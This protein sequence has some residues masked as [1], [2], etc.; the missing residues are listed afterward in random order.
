MIQNLFEAKLS[1]GAGIGSP[2]VYDASGFSRPC[3]SFIISRGRN[4]SVVSRYG[5][6][7][8]DISSWQ[9]ERRPTTLYFNF[10]RKGQ[11]SPARDRISDD[12]RWLMFAMIWL[13][14]GI[15]F[16]CGTLMAYMIMIRALAVYSDENGI[17]ILE[18]LGDEATLMRF[19]DRR[20]SNAK[21]KSL[22][23]MLAHLV[24][25]GEKLLGFSLVGERA[26]ERIQS[27]SRHLN[28]DCKQTP[29]IP[30]GAYLAILQELSNELTEWEQV[31]SECLMIL[32]N[33]SADKVYG[34]RPNAQAAAIRCQQTAVSRKPSWTEIASTKLRTYLY[35][36]GQ[37][38]DISGLVS[39]VTQIQL[40][41]KLS[42]QAYSGMR[43]DEARS[44]P[45]NCSD[46]L[47]VD[48][49]VQRFVQGR[50]TKLSRTPKYSRWVTNREGHR[51]ITIAQEIAKMIY[52]ANNVQV[53]DVNLMSE[54]N[55]GR[56]LLVSTAYLSL[57]GRRRQ[58]PQD[59]FFFAGCMSLARFKRMRSRLQPMIKESDIKELEQID[60]HRSWRSEQCF[61]IG[62]PWP[63]ETHQLRRS[64]AL[65]AQRSGLV[66]L[67]SLRR[68]LQHITEE[69]TR[70]YAKGSLHAMQLFGTEEPN[71]GHFCFEWQGAQAESAATSYA[72]N[73]LFTDETLFGAHAAFVRHRLGRVPNSDR[74]QLRAETLKMFRAGELHYRETILG[75]CTR[76]DDACQSVA[77]D[78]LNVNCIAS[79]CGNLVGNFSKLQAVIKEQERHVSTLSTTSLLYRTEHANLQVLVRARDNVKAEG[80]NAI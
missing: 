23:A 6:L 74:V 32:K 75:G 53:T 55:Q 77:L 31:A 67:P 56:P 16:S 29:P 57:S 3:D 49:K 26:Q 61:Q 34:R 40:V 35:D 38:D 51:A 76:E 44:L 72:S 50:T 17:G 11:A 18:A 71:R 52:A 45:Y 39:V 9:T 80:G 5:D 60:Q 7:M 1:H 42:I 41:A 27:R 78:W 69:M 2:D 64:L 24:R 59:G 73:V 33:C 37:R 58:V 8:W 22:C 4:N 36:R 19:A 65:Y 15:P 13:R 46:Y 47:E 30:M 62:G 21:I 70:Y 25:I 20:C 10:W 54:P 63:L 28:A 14:E 79:N 48:G 66:T 12:A 43:D 68:Q